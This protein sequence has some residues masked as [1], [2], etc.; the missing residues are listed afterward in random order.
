[1]T[2]AEPDVLRAVCKKLGID[3]IKGVKVAY[4]SMIPSLQAR[5]CGRDRRG[6]RS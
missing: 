2:G 1:M 4:E 3:D 5:T 6:P